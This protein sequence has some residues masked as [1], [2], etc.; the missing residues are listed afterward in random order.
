MYEIAG[1]H[2]DPTTDLRAR[3]TICQ[4]RFSILYFMDRD[5]NRFP[6][7]A[8]PPKTVQGSKAIVRIKKADGTWEELDVINDITWS[9]PGQAVNGRVCECGARKTG[10]KDFAPG[11]SSWC[12][13]KEVP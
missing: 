3:C 13:V 5:I 6:V 4:R 7:C 2:F 11:H 1:H 9:I 8:G 12:P 10:V